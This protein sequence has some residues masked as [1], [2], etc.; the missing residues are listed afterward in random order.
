MAMNLHK[1]KLEQN[2]KNHDGE[3]RVLG[4]LLSSNAW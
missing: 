3:F 2:L 1:K 4:Q